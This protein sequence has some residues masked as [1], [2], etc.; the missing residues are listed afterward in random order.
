MKHTNPATTLKEMMPRA[1]QIAVLYDLELSNT[2]HFKLA[3]RFMELEKQL[4]KSK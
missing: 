2:K 1:S 4:K 3:V